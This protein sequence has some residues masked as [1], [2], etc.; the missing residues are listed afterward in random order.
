MTPQPHS[1]VNDDFVAVSI[2]FK[3]AHD[4][5]AAI[6]FGDASFSPS[7]HCLVRASGWWGLTSTGHAIVNGQQTPTTTPWKHMDF[8]TLLLDRRRGV[9]RA[10]HNY[11]MVYVFQDAWACLPLLCMG[12]IGPFKP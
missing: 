12:Q 5:L 2:C 1:V 11:S 3:L 4:S 6:G 8:I 9:M 7:H 10:W